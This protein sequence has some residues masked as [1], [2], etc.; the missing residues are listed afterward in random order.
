MIIRQYVSRETIFDTAP[1][2]Y[3]PTS[4]LYYDENNLLHFTSINKDY[5][6]QSIRKYFTNRNEDNSNSIGNL[7]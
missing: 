2:S 5:Y 7:I 3:D 4:S 6:S 1:T